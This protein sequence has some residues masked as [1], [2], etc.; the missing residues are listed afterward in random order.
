M[1][2]DR[3]PLL[4]AAVA[5]LVVLAIVFVAVQCEAS[6][7][8]QCSDNSLDATTMEVAAFSPSKP[9]E[10]L[11]ARGSVRPKPNGNGGGS[12]FGVFVIYDNDCD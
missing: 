9:G 12:F 6:S 5:I 1:S 11:L 2:N 3:R 4:K 8:G 10:T 7:D